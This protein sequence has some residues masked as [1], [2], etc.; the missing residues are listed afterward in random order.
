MLARFYR[1]TRRLTPFMWQEIDE[2]IL[3]ALY[4]AASP[5][6][7]GGEFYGPRGFCELAGGGVKPAKIPP[8]CQE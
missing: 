2:G 5:Q 8:A 7:Q 4:A 3:P 1:A 6:A